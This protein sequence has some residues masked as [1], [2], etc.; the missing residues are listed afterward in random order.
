MT[1]TICDPVHDFD[2]DDPIARPRAWKKADQLTP[3]PPKGWLRM[4]TLPSIPQGLDIGCW[5][6]ALWDIERQ[7]RPKH[8]GAFHTVA[9]NPDGGR[10]LLVHPIL[11]S[12]AV[13][14]VVAFNGA[15]TQCD[16]GGTDCLAGDKQHAALR[17][18]ARRAWAKRPIHERIEL[19]QCSNEEDI[20]ISMAFEGP[21]FIPHPR[22]P[23]DGPN[24]GFLEE[25]TGAR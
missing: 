15:I 23:C 19:I 5:I 6:C 22:D 18:L 1:K 9:R 17:V 4:L 2:E 16:C 24:S 10:V 3:A 8:L 14:A 21:A 11:H 25:I 12:F 7:E 13:G 20:D